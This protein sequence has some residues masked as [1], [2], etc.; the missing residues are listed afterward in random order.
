MSSSVT[1][2][3]AEDVV[4]EV[5]KNKDEDKKT[6]ERDST[7]VD[8]KKE[9]EKEVE[10]DNPHEEIIQKSKILVKGPEVIFPEVYP[11][12]LFDD[13]GARVLCFC[14]GKE[15][16]PYRNN[17]KPPY[18]WM[19][20]PEWACL[21]AT[22]LLILV[23]ALAFCIWLAPQVHT[24]LA[25][26]GYLLLFIDILFLTL[27]AFSDPGYVP[28]RSEPHPDHLDEHGNPK[29]RFC[30]TCNV[31]KKRGQYHCHTCGACVLEMDHH[32][33]WTGTCIGKGNIL[34][35]RCY[36]SL[37]CVL[38]LYCAVGLILLATSVMFSYDTGNT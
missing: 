24:L 12:V 35:F 14:P 32:C 22:Y 38:V 36:T 21:G 3:G 7:L 37:L 30:R 29:G 25:I 20:G 13:T 1:P 19:I 27:C 6:I 18:L 23:P 8:E 9:A 28:K 31:P 34:W 4:L 33:P 5:E 17:Y 15:N 26:G 10:K 2:D 16:K 11:C